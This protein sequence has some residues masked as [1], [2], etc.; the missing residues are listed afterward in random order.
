MGGSGAAPM[1][2]GPVFWVMYVFIVPVKF[3]WGYALA[4][5]FRGCSSG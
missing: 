2:G 4:A 1:G 5:Y 3:P